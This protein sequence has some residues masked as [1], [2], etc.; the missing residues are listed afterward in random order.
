VKSRDR[1]HRDIRCVLNRADLK[2][3]LSR[4]YY[5]ID[6]LLMGNNAIRQYGE[7]ERGIERVVDGMISDASKMSGIEVETALDQG[8]MA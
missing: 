2:G 7:L 5:F 3:D 1:V 8:V 6:Q 4:A